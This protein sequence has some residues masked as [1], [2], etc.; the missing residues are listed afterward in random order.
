MDRPRPLDWRRSLPL[1]AGGLLIAAYILVNA[2]ALGG[3]ELLLNANNHVSNMVVVSCAVFAILMWTQTGRKHENRQ[4]W[5][6][7]AIGWTLWAVADAWWT[8]ANV[9]GAEVPY[10]SAADIFWLAG[11][12]P[13]FAALGSRLGSLPKNENYLKTVILWSISLLV[14]GWTTLFVLVPILRDYDPSLLLQSILNILY[15]LADLVLLLLAL[16]IF[17]AFQR[18]SY[19]RTWLLLALGFALHAIS[20]LAFSFATNSNLYYPQNNANLLS[21]VGVDVTYTLGYLVCLAG[22]LMLRNTQTAHTPYRRPDAPLAMIPN[23]HVLIFTKA[24]DLVVDMSKNF[25]QVFPA[26]GEGQKSLAETLGMGA[27][28]ARIISGEMKVRDVFLERP[29]AVKTRFGDQPARLSA[30]PILGPSGEYQ[31]GIYLVR[32]MMAS[33]TL[34]RLL[35]DYERSIL[36]NLMIKTLASETSEDEIKQYLGDYFSAY[37]QALYL[38][39]VV[40]GGEHLGEAMITD[41]RSGLQDL[42]LNLAVQT[43]GRLHTDLSSMEEVQNGLPYLLDCARSFAAQIFGEETVSAEIQQVD[44]W[45]ST[46][47]HANAKTFLGR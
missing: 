16:W 26:P 5:V 2:L 21:T 6:G 41:L 14:L 25:S 1:I 31:G 46:I 11:Y 20:D 7:L 34:D 32:L 37:L 22:M 33:N 27:D 9:F 15:P 8:V 13:M 43:D 28:E 18:G 38:L 3:G 39:L 35:S 36:S 42:G 4:L 17:F 10:P 12:V 24:N 44:G 45:F 40:K 47:E 29:V 30:L 23:T 19:G